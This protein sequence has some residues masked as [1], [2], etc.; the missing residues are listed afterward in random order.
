MYNNSYSLFTACVF[1]SIE[2]TIEKFLIKIKTKRSK[3]SRIIL[4]MCLDFLWKY[5]RS[6]L[7]KQLFIYS[8]TDEP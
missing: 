5:L 7:D 8:R 3:K 4:M 6:H 2:E 1:Y